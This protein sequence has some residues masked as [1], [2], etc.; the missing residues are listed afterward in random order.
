[1]YIMY[2]CKKISKVKNIKGRELGTY[3]N[4][5]S[6]VAT[7]KVGIPLPYIHDVPKT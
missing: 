3:L 4:R 2:A 7:L 5:E 1:M 6:D